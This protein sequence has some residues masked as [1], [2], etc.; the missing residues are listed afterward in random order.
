MK[1]SIIINLFIALNFARAEY[2]YETLD[3]NYNNSSSQS[4]FEVSN[5]PPTKS[6]DGVGLCYAFTSSTLLENYRCKE[7]KLNCL[8][9]DNLISTLDVASFNQDR[10]IRQLKEGGI[11]ESLLRS[12]KNSN[13]KLARENCAKFSTIIHKINNTNDANEGYGWKFLSRSWNNFKKLT[14]RRQKDLVWCMVGAVKNN[15]QQIE[16]PEDQLYDAFLNARNLENFLYKT[17]LP[18]QCLQ[19]NNLMLIPDFNV[20]TYPARNE[21]VN[22]QQLEQKIETVLLNNIPIEMGICTY[23]IEKD[24]ACPENQAHSITLFGIRESCNDSGDCRTMVR[25]KNSYGWSWQQQNND[26]WVELS[27]LTKAAT[28]L[29]NYDNITWLTKPNQKL[30]NKKLTRTGNIN[31]VNSDPL[32]TLI[33]NNFKP[34]KMPAEYKTFKG[35]WKCPGNKYVDQYAPGCTPY[36]KM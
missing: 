12:I 33:Q 31:K 19:E 22:Q 3:G 17:I 1:F 30:E 5:M 34:E 26:G 27:T 11:P 35:I 29:Q 23:E 7:L 15:L 8:E 10:E 20:N 25:I 9:K 13:K 16:T 6:Q 2:P 18:T 14:P 21:K 28:D 4:T 24:Q 36:M 32:G